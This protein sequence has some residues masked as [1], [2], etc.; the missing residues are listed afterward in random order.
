MS[1]AL[2]DDDPIHAFVDGVKKADQSRPFSVPRGQLEPHFEQDKNG[3]VRARTG[4]TFVFKPS[5][6]PGEPAPGEGAGK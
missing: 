5:R 6:L 4:E 1:I 2:E 3:N